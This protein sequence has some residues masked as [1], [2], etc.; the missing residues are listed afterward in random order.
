[1]LSLVPVL[2]PFCVPVAF[3]AGIAALATDAALVTT[4]NGDWK[5][6][7][8]DA[9]LMALPA[10]AGRLRGAIIS[11]RASRAAASGRRF[12]Q[13]PW[14]KAT[15]LSGKAVRFRQANASFAGNVAV[16]RYRTVTGRVRFAV[17]RSERSRTAFTHAEVALVKELEKKGVRFSRVEEVYSELEPCIVPRRC[18]RMVVREFP[19][20]RLSYSF[21]Y[22]R[23]FPPQGDLAKRSREAG[24]TA[25]ADAVKGRGL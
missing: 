9:A 16:A 17:A 11:T 24:R 7:A 18:R 3:I 15:N 21:E 23:D 4:G 13:V 20:S 19:R 14:G 25:L 8:V 6:L 10:G 5:T 2:A 1:M 12:A 22:G